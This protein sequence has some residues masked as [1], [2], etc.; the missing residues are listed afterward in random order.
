MQT[1]QRRAIPV[2]DE[3][4]FAKL[5]ARRRRLYERERLRPLAEAS[6]IQDLAQRLFPNRMVENQFD[7]EVRL[8]GSCLSELASLGVFIEGSRREFYRALLNRYTVENLKVLLRLFLRDKSPEEAPVRLVDLPAAFALPRAR[9]MDSGNVQEFL[10]RVP[11]PQ[12]REAALQAA[13]RRGDSS[14][15]AVLEMAIDQGWWRQVGR[16]FLALSG[17][18]RTACAP[19]TGCEYDGTRLVAV[20]RAAQA[21]QLPWEE[22]GPLVSNGWGRIDDDDLERVCMRQQE[23]IPLLRRAYGLLVEPQ[24]VARVTPLEERIWHHTVEMAERE[25]RATQ[26]GFAVLVSYFYLKHEELRHLLSITQMLRR[27]VSTDDIMDY[28]AHEQ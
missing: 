11:I 2:P 7:L 18:D 8:Q 14:A 15:P 17:S 9:L 25:F 21:Y 13:G 1:A 4:L 20:L 28:L 5:R 6:N 10:S 12:V 26:K 23:A 3:F 24:D 19:L 16:C 22:I 27:G